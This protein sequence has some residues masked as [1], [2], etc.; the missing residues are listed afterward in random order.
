MPALIL[1]KAPRTRTRPSLL[2]FSHDCHPER[3]EAQPNVV[4]GSRPPSRFRTFLYSSGFWNRTRQPAKR[5]PI[6]ISSWRVGHVC[7]AL[8]SPIVIPRSGSDAESLFCN[9]GLP[10][11]L[12]VFEIWGFSIRTFPLRRR[13]AHVRVALPSPI[14]IP[15]SA[16]DAESL[17]C[18]SPSLTPSLAPDLRRAA[19]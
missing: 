8:P 12:A 17:F 18:N 7:V 13:V 2:R 10:H 19:S 14:V 5:E 15:R 3:S 16:S 4:E 11:Y 1:S 9:R 6:H